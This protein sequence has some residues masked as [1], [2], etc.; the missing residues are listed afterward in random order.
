MSTLIAGAVDQLVPRLPAL[1]PTEARHAWDAGATVIDLRSPGERLRDGDLAGA[2]RLSPDQLA[3]LD[4]SDETTVILVCGAGDR[5]DRL[6]GILHRR[7]FGNVTWVGGGYRAWL[8][9]IWRQWSEML[10]CDPGTPAA[11]FARLIT[12]RT[13][14]P[15]PRRDHEGAAHAAG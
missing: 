11:R 7:G 8:E 9:A 4:L 15:V 10:V 12:H 3:D 6:A 13:G 14:V 5:S 2:L 1:S